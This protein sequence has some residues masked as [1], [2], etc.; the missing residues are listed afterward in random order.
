MPPKSLFDAAHRPDK[1]VMP[2]CDECNRG[3]STADITASIVSRWRY[4]ISGR[5]RSD[6]L[7][8]IAQVR[9]HS[10]E[11]IKEWTNMSTPDKENAKL[12][13]KKYGAHVPSDAGVVAIGP[14]TIRQL[15]LFAHKTVLGLYFEH[16]RELLPN[17][18]RVSAY[19]RTKEDFAQGLPPALLEMM[20]SY[21]TLEQGKWNAREAFEY[22]YEVNKKDGLFA[23]LARLRAML[24]ITGFAAK[25]A[26]TLLSD[27]AGD[28]VK[29]SELLGKMNE[30]IFEKRQ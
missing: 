30:P 15:N 16:F 22:R 13:L 10:P 3:T 19:W 27:Q 14:L 25:D 11:L 29:P 4:D 2:A 23:C 28:W 18:G 21:G 24:F 8:L 20:R 9:M 7:R 12:H 1:L 6:H 26:S 5:E 17:T